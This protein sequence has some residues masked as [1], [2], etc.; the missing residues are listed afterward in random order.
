MEIWKDIEGYEGLYQV[1]SL[2]RVKSIQ[3]SV[4]REYNKSGVSQIKEKILKPFI[5]NTG[6][7]AIS[8]SKNSKLTPHHIH[9]LVAV[10]FI[11]NPENKAQVNHIGKN[12]EGKI[13]QLDNR[14]ISLEWATPKEN[15]NH[16]WQNGL[17]ENVRNSAKKIV[18][19]RNSR[20]VFDA[21]NKITYNSVK[22]AA[23]SI[24]INPDN[25]SGML[26]GD[27]PNTT[28]FTYLY[29]KISEKK[30]SLLLSTQT[31]IF[32]ESYKE[33]SL[34]YSIKRTTLR[35]ML[36][37]ANKNKTDLVTV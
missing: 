16:A 21:I 18:I 26:R 20:K 15:I 4:I 19:A 5:N 22:E 30:G 11:P 12:A 2:G 29:S 1:S 33:A 25:L 32:Y 17:C 23:I 34:V 6:Y 9:R 8:L 24:G 31:G 14:A 27:Y 36:S 37:G 35:A 28:S 13:D 10:T 7:Y 3:R